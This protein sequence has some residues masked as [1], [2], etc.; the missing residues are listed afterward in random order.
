MGARLSPQRLHP[1]LLDLHKKSNTLSMK[2]NWRLPLRHNRDVDDIVTKTAHL[3]SH[4]NGHVKPGQRTA[5][6]CTCRRN[7]GH[8]N[9]LAKNCN[10]GTP[11][12]ALSGPQHLSCATTGKTTCPWTGR[13]HVDDL[14]NRDIDHHVEEQY[15]TQQETQ[16]AP[17]SRRHRPAR[18][19]PAHAC[20]RL[21]LLGGGKDPISASTAQREG[22]LRD[23]AFETKGSSALDRCMLTASSLCTRLWL[24]PSFTSQLSNKGKE[25]TGY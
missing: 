14:H 20:H 13:A 12:A 17:P 3:A 6:S 1:N 18:R 5:P 2:C 25:L 8:V 7:N 15:E 21:L 9:T 16:P 22:I 11:R 4:N 19:L 10:C 24:T 23:A